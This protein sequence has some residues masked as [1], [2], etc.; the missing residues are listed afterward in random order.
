MLYSAYIY[1]FSLGMGGV[2]E[3]EREEIFTSGQRL[4]K[5]IVNLFCECCGSWIILFK[6][7]QNH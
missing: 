7:T 1:F 2:T 3:S 6:F 4:D 5:C